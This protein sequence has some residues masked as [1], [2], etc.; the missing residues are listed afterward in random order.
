VP[1]FVHERRPE[2]HREENAQDERRPAEAGRPSDDN[3][4]CDESRRSCG[5]AARERVLQIRAFEMLLE[6]R[7]KRQNRDGGSYNE[8]GITQAS[9]TKQDHEDQQPEEQCRVVAAELHNRITN[10]IEDRTVCAF[11][12]SMEESPDRVVPPEDLATPCLSAKQQEDDDQT[13]SDE[14]SRESF[15]PS[16][17]RLA[18][19]QPAAASF[20]VNCHLSTSPL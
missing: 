15:E 20:L 16:H 13:R 1:I 12:V 6:Q 3:C 5:M 4:R 9:G 2:A 7:R 10:V 18:V 8:E 19:A 11:L 17:A 14:D